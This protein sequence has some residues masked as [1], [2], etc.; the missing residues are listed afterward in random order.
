MVCQSTDGGK[1]RQQFERMYKLWQL[2]GN[3]SQPSGRFRK[4]KH[5]NKSFYWNVIG[6]FSSPLPSLDVFGDI[7]YEGNQA[8]SCQSQWRWYRF[9]QLDAALR[10]T[11]CTSSRA[12][13]HDCGLGSPLV[14]S[15]SLWLTSLANPPMFSHSCSFKSHCGSTDYV[16]MVV[17]GVVYLSRSLCH[18]VC[19][20]V[21]G[22]SGCAHPTTRHTCLSS[23]TG[24]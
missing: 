11:Y 17:V 13:S 1:K 6:N 23:N 14:K 20:T 19:F 9:I 7:H 3:I 24:A 8:E 2:N 5:E 21:R 18:S 4:E 15:T 10:N 22:A 12:R 16:F